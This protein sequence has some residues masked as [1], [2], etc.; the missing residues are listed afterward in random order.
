MQKAHCGEASAVPFP[1][2]YYLITSISDKV[3]SDRF[4]HRVYQNTSEFLGIFATD[5]QFDEKPN[6]TKHTNEGGIKCADRITMQ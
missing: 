4:V 2:C 6:K 1:F 3:C 5:F